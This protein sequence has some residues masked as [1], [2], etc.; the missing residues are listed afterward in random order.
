MLGELYGEAGNAASATLDQNGF[1]RFELRRILEGPQRR[2]AGQ[3]HGSRLGMAEAVRLLGDDLGLDGDLFRVRAFD[4]LIHDPEHRIADGEVSDPRADRADHA[5][6]VA[7]QY[8]RERF[9]LE[10]PLPNRTL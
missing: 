5:R 6:E 3:R 2:N 9:I 8:I 4:A 7:A 10:R 1:A